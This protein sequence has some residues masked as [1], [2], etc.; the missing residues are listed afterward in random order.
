MC[1]GTVQ[2]S[3][4]W[5]RILQVVVWT[6]RSS[7]I[8]LGTDYLPTGTNF[9]ECWARIVPTLQKSFYLQKIALCPVSSGKNLINKLINEYNTSINE[10]FVSSY[11]LS[12]DRPF[13][14][15]FQ[16]QFH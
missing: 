4:Q 16:F 13:Q 12:N 3:L 2:T 11:D 5:R 15:Q 10:V 9:V 14:F 7:I 8:T 6:L 1:I